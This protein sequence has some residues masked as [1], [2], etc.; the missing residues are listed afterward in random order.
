MPMFVRRTILSDF[1]DVAAL[2]QLMA[3]D[4]AGNCLL[5]AHIEL[6]NF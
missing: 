6:T 2:A 4:R 3:K 1:K 5:I